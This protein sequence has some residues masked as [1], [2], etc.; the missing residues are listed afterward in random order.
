MIRAFLPAL[1]LVATGLAAP[2]LA[3][4]PDFGTD[5]SPWSNDGECDDPRFEGPGMTLTPL[6]ESDVLAD[7]TD[8]RTAFTAGTI[9]L[10]GG[11]AAP[12]GKGGGTVPPPVPG[13]VNF[14]DDS[15]E[16]ANDGE[17][18]DR[19][20][21]GPG[22]AAA[23]GWQNTGRD[24]T[25]CRALLDAGQVR[26]WVMAEAVAATQCGAIGF[27]DDSGEFAAD[28][29]C[30][31]MRFEGPGMASVVNGE[32]VNRDATDCRQHCTYGIVALRDY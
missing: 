1:A 31:D 7:A 24:A 22:M 16:W 28:G 13:A 29:E 3:Q 5:S 12:P 2:A 19:R 14:G 11:V 27:G 6:L 26:L 18:D 8:C 32:S 21:V 4:A 17:C 30:D 23:L 10:V 20:F 15:N 9:T 25:D